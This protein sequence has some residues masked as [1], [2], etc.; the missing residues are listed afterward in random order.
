MI[1]IVH[2]HETFWDSFTFK[3][4]LLVTKTER[5]PY[6]YQKLNARVV[7]QHR[8]QRNAIPELSA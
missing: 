3:Q 4:S 1:F 8:A 2:F 7:K 6:H 5:E